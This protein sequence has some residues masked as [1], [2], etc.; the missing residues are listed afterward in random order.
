MHTTGQC[1]TVSSA[2]QVSNTLI[3][4]AVTDLSTQKYVPVLQWHTPHSSQLEVLGASGRMQFRAMLQ[5]LLASWCLPSP[6]CV[7]L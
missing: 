5:D 6:A 7:L 1:T 2:G 3:T 4:T